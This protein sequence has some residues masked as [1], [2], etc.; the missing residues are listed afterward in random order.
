MVKAALWWIDEPTASADDVKA[1]AKAGVD[2]LDRIT[3][4]KRGGELLYGGKTR[5]EAQS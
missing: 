4:W 5:N 2:E 1:R 3:A